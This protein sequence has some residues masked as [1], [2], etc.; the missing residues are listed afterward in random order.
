M[1]SSEN[2]ALKRMTFYA[3]QAKI[4]PHLLGIAQPK[5]LISSEIVTQM[6]SESD[7]CGFQQVQ[8]ILHP[9]VTLR[10]SFLE[11]LQRFHL[12]LHLYVQPEKLHP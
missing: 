7:H 5:P 1:A 8:A 11:L 3:L 6:A 9:V 2:S 12:A 10:Q 4:C